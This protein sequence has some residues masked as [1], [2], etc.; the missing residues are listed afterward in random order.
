M[1]KFEDFIKKSEAR[2][3]L[4]LVLIFIVVGI[5]N[6][7]FLSINNIQTTLKSSLIYIILAV[8]LSFVLLTGN[9][10][11]SVG[12]TLGLC[13][14]V[15][16]LIIKDGGSI[17]LAIVVALLIGGIIGLIN[18]LGVTKLKIASFIMTLGI[19]GITK[20]I[21]VIYTDGKWV[22]NLPVAF[23]KI[24]QIEVFGINILLILVMITVILVHL[25]L[26]KSNKGRYFSAI[27][28][29][30]D[31]AILLGVPVNRYVIYSFVI[32]GIC[33]GLAGVVF[34]SQV[35]FIS[36]KAGTGIEMTVIAAAVLGGVSLNGGVGSVLGA[37][38]GAIIMIC[39]N[40]ALVYLK[41]PAFWN[42]AISGALLITIVVVDAFFN[43]R[44]E[45]RA[46]RQ[47]M[48]ARILQKTESK[49]N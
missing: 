25:Y 4:F 23:K 43:R 39:I 7:D 14:A 38:L 47:R 2:T 48:N 12:G 8:G 46:K 29:N 34:S 49:I 19:L 40:S 10:D 41:I 30:V 20:V 9:I 36:T 6:S 18:G 31:G 22:E 27:G 37:S 26:T 24:S 3:L 28:D 1:S 44:A 17:F 11:I 13:A 21:H 45:K 5:V 15:C 33:A 35:G 42:D 32:S 16:G